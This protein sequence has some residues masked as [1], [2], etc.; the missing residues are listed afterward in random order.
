MKLPR[1]GA[2]H[3]RMALRARGW[4]P[5]HCKLILDDHRDPWVTIQVLSDCSSSLLLLLQ[6]LLLCWYSLLEL[7]CLLT[8]F[9][10]PHFELL[11]I[12][13]SPST[14]FIFILTLFYLR[15]LRSRVVCYICM[16]LIP[17]GFLVYSFHS[18]FTYNNVHAESAFSSGWLLTFTT[19]SYLSITGSLQLR[20][21]ISGASASSSD[22][23]ISSGVVSRFVVW[24]LLATPPCHTIHPADSISIPCGQ[25]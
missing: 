10:P 15:I 9:H 5:W 25:L 18:A 24:H 11:S 7:D 14:S 19:L 22:P 23:E 13:Y 20:V 21:D 4:S 2:P 8:P 12:I 3:L 1:M 6:L 16:A 17:L